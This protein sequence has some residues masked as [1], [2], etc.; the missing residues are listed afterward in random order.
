MKTTKCIL[1]IAA[2]TI[3]S[4][5]NA[6]EQLFEKK[7]INHYRNVLSL[8][9]LSVLVGGFEMA[10]ENLFSP[11]F[12]MRLM[13]GYFLNSNQTIYNSEFEGYRIEFQARYY[14]KDFNDGNFLNNYYVAPFVCY[15]EVSIK[16]WNWMGGSKTVTTDAF[17]T[18]FNV[19][20]HFVNKINLTFDTWLG[21]SIVKSLGRGSPDLA[22]IPFVNQYKNGVIPRF[23]MSVGYCF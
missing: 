11:N 8:Q 22:N 23:G 19:G 7:E 12:S 5:V 16:Q 17:Q 1:L 21:V 2:F 18:G 10:Y 14:F 9:P 20:Y 6:Q 4:K 15:K 3:C 13:G